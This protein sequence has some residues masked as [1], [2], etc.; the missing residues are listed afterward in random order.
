M[1]AK[2]LA[3]RVNALQWRI[4]KGV[5]VEVP[6]DDALTLHQAAESLRRWYRMEYGNGRGQVT[7][8]K[9]GRSVFVD[10]VTTKAKPVPDREA[11]ALREVMEVCTRCGLAYRTSHDFRGSVLFVFSQ[12]DTAA[13][14]ASVS[15]E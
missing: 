4:W 8:D 14:P 12:S 9:S 5:G 6:Y 11:M 1:D 3:V 15:C 2:G 13:R 7:R 10:C